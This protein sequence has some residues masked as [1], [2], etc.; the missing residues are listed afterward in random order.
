MH[1]L[2]LA[3]LLPLLAAPSGPDPIARAVAERSREAL[4]TAASPRGTAAL[5]RLDELREYVQEDRLIERTLDQVAKGALTD[6]FT[7]TTARMLQLQAARE[8]GDVPRARRLTSELGFVQ[9]VSVLGPFDNEGKSGCDVDF[10]P[11]ASLDLGAAHPAKG[12]VAR[13]RPLTVAS[14]DGAVD[15]SSVLRPNRS[16]VAYALAL[17]DEPAARRVTLGL[18]TAGAFR[19]WVNG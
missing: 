8:Q 4:S 17:L 5:L 18:G 19:L 11:E 15:L 9:A 6:P 2:P 7:R 12:S 13:W 10:G 16:V 1:Q 14:L 3:L